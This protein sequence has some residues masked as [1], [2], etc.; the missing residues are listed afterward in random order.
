M[1]SQ[2]KNSRVG[3]KPPKNTKELAERL[4]VLPRYLVGGQWK[5]KSKGKD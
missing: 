1:A 3:R 5:A 4:Q 2:S